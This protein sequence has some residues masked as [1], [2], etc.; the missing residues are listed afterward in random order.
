[1]DPN[2]TLYLLIEAAIHDGDDN[3]VLIYA[4]SLARWLRSGGFRPTLEGLQQAGLEDLE[5]K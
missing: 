5:D 3:S 2:Q 1:M 4:D